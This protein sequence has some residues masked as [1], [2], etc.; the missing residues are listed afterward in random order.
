MRCFI[1]S[2]ENRIKEIL[3]IWIKLGEEGKIC[4][5][6]KKSVIVIV[7]EVNKDNGILNT[8]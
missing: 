1:Q 4:E 7:L 2:W 3:I 5:E 6:G 8:F